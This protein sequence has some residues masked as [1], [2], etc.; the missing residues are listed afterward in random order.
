MPAR[1]GI[2]FNGFLNPGFSFCH[3]I[4]WIIAC[5]Y[6]LLGLRTIG[7]IGLCDDFKCIPE[8]VVKVILECKQACSVVCQACSVVCKHITF[9]RAVEQENL[10]C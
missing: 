1:Q 7:D 6:F 9:K 4:F 2:C 8:K 5:F 10:A 3:W